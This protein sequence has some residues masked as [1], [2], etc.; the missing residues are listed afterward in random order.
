MNDTER[1]ATAFGLA[2]EL[3]ANDVGRFLNVEEIVE[4]EVYKCHYADSCGHWEPTT[5][6]LGDG[7]A[8]VSAIDVE[9]QEGWAQKFNV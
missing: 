7:V 8:T 9:T 2:Y 5:V 3:D 1:V 6:V 4:G